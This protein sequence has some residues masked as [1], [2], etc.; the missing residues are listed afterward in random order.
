M[1]GKLALALVALGCAAAL[2]PAPALAKTARCDITTAD[3]ERYRGPCDFTARK[4]GSFDL[5][6]PDAA[7]EIVYVNYIEVTLTAP[8]RARIAGSVPGLG[9]LNQW[10]LVLRDKKAPACWQGEW[11]RV[12]VY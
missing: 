10:G 8:G 11:G 3:G 12:C 6:L 4:G 1:N 5:I 2:T 9:K 7:A